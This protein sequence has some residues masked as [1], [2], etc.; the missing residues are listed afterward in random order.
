MR[1]RIRLGGAVEV[2]GHGGAHGRAYRRLAMAV[3]P[4][5]NQAPDAEA[6]FKAV[7][8]ALD[9]VRAHESSTTVGH[10]TSATAANV[11]NAT[12]EVCTPPLPLTDRSAAA[13]LSVY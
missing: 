11:A 9:L 10:A 3:H 13:A 12:A 8:R 1:T 6:A 5:K 4:D 7:R 2:S